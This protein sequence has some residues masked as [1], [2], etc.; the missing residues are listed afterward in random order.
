MLKPFSLFSVLLF[1]VPSFVLSTLLGLI[2]AEAQEPVPVK[3]VKQTDGWQLLRDGKPY[4]INGAGGDGPL[5]MLAQYGGNSSRVWG[6][7]SNTKAR[8]DEAHQN[9]LTLSLIHI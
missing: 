8:L 6:V 2:P 4:Y 3:V 7:D 5:K 1:A 9:G